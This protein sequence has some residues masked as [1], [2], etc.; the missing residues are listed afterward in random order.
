MAFRFC[1]NVRSESTA[2][3]A[4]QPE[5]LALFLRGLL[6]GRM[7]P[8]SDALGARGRRN[9][10]PALPCCSAVG[11]ARV[12]RFGFRSLPSL[13]AALA[14]EP[15]DNAEDVLGASASESSEPSRSITE[16]LRFGTCS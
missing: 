14:F 12:A 9:N 7:Y 8:I 3:P 16:N 6:L 5:V 10:R 13:R 1:E 11:A 15:L 4:F 2:D